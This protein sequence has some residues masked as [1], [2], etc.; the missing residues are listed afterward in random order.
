MSCWGRLSVSKVD[1]HEWSMGERDREVVVVL[2]RNDRTVGRGTK[3]RVWDF[4]GRSQ[5]FCKRL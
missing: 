1:F 5:I 3:E 4:R 2:L